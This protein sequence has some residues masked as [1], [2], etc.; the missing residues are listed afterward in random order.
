[1]IW[2]RLLVKDD[3]TIADLHYCIQIIFMW[4]DLHL[5]QFII[6]GKSYGL[7]Y[8]GGINFS[9]NANKIFLDQFQFRLNERFIYEYDFTDNWEHEIRVE[10]LLPANPQKKYPLC[11][12]GG[13]A[14]PPEDCGGPEAFMS[15]LD[16]YPLDLPEEIVGLFT[17]YKNGGVDIEDIEEGIDR[18]D[19]WV[20]QHKFD[21]KAAN[22]K[23]KKYFNNVHREDVSMEEVIDEY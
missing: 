21:R 14:A 9:D 4:S 1:M 20:N 13:R 19:Y 3:H 17:E 23:L 7:N 8:Y 11:I 12:S 16:Q 6:H 10:K 18:F 22:R 15:L 2:R 5:H